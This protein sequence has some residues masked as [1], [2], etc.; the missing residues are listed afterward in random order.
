MTKKTKKIGPKILIVAK[1]NKI[2]LKLARKLEKVLK[3]YSENIHFDRSTAIKFRTMGMSIKKFDG[4]FI[5]TLGGDGTFLWTAHKA[6]VPILPVRIEG[7][8]F[9][10]TV[11]FKELMKNL[12]K[13]FKKEYTLIEK[14]RLKC[15]KIKRGKIAKYLQK[16]LRSEYPFAL[17]EIAFARKRPSKILVIEFTIDDTVFRCIGDGVMFSTPSGSTAY[18]ASAGGP[19]IDPKL[20][21]I[22]II[23]L[24]PFYSKLKPIVVPADKK[25]EVKIIG[26]D[27]AL[28]IDGHGGEYVKSGSEF[29]IER[30]KP[31]KVINLTKQ[32]FYEKLNN[33]LF[34]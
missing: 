12:P 29:I 1:Q 24:Y 23:P 27:C 15:S 2:G 10:C 7:S 22:S 21:V 4:D 32:N 8:G 33:E 25:I 19:I 20:N 30:G 14:M 9:L 3:N 34:K 6:N 13:L 31:V 18:S 5:I 28:I 17:N 16:I 11:N 26:G